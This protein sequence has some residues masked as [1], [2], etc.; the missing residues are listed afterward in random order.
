[1]H[2]ILETPRLRL[3]QF[4]PDDAAFV[5]ELI[6]DPDWIAGIRDAGVREVGAARE[7][8]QSR[9]VEPCW[10][11]GHGF[12]RVESRDR[13]EPLGL[14]GVFKR[15][16]LPIPDL[17]YGF[18]RRHRGHGYAREAAGACLDYA[19]QV[20]GRDEL[21]A[22]T[23]PH[24]ERSQQLLRDLGFV[25]EGEPVRS[26]D[27]LTQHWR[28]RSRRAAAGHRSD[29]EQLDDLVRRFFT[30]FDNRAGRIATAPAL[31]AFFMPDA[32]IRVGD[33]APC[34]VRDFL[35]PRLELLASRLREF[36][37]WELSAQTQVAAD[38]QMAQRQSRYA[39]QGQLDGQPYG[40]QGRK[41]FHFVRDAEGRWRIGRLSWLDD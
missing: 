19:Q 41:S 29:E 4:M 2:L 34:S 8:L 37:E 23:A 28:W 30:A 20:L 21:L 25:A 40:G 12:W 22:I 5:L 1:M 3:R 31:P 38:G 18:L 33:Q 14:C 17:G 15:D 7:W 36:H 24:N 27:G 11:H 16:T 13:A 39:K 6:N 32:D 10:Q 9:L 26:D 35:A